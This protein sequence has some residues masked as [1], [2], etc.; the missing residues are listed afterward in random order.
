[1]SNA[2]RRGRSARYPIQSP[3]LVFEYRFAE[4]AAEGVVVYTDKHWASCR[5]TRSFT[6]GG[7]L[8]VGGAL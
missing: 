8:C 5:T 3:E 7:A 1:M 4:S 2:M 6:S